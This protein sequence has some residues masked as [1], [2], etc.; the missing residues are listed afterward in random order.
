MSKGTKELREDGFYWIVCGSCG[1][2]NRR[3]HKDAKLSTGA[4]VHNALG[5]RGKRNGYYCGPCAAE[6]L[7]EL[8]EEV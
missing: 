6:K 4:N 3:E 5:D 2:N 7:L 8:M 1:E